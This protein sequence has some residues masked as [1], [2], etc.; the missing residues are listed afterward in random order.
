VHTFHQPY[1]VYGHTA[2]EMFEFTADAKRV[3]R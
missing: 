1:G 3:R 2:T